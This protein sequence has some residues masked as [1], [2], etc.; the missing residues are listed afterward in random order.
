MTETQW[1]EE[2]V[3][4]EV[5]AGGGVPGWV[6]GCGCGCLVLPILGPSNPRDTIGL[7]GDTAAQPH[8][9]FLPFWM[10]S[11]IRATYLLN[12]RSLL[13]DDIAAERASALDFYVFVRNAYVQ[14]RD[15]Q[16]HDREEGEKSGASGRDDGLYYPDQSKGN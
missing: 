4:Q 8:Q 11:A 15:N 10:T 2:V 13:L 6:W 1:G 12:K 7:I 3:E 9:Y 14:K 5:T 16:V